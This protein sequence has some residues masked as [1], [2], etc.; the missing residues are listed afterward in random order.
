MEVSDP[1]EVA[2]TLAVTDDDGVPD[3]APV[4]DGELD[5]VAVEETVAHGVDVNV[6]ATVADTVGVEKLV[7][8]AVTDIDTVTVPDFPL[9]VDDGDTLAVNDADLVVD[10]VALPDAHDAV[11]L[12]VALRHAVPEFEK[13]RVG[14]GVAD[15]LTDAVIERD[16]PTVDETLGLLVALHEKRDEN[17]ARD[18][19]GVG[20]D[21][22]LSDAETDAVE[23][24]VLDG[25]TDTRGEVVVVCV[26][27]RE[28]ETETVADDDGVPLLDA[29]AV[30]LAEPPPLTDEVT[31]GD[32]DAAGDALD[33]VDDVPC[34]DSVAVV[35]TLDVND[36]EFEGRL[37]DVAWPL[38]LP[39]PLGNRDRDGDGV[40]DAL[41][42]T[43]P[44]VVGHTLELQ[45]V[46]GDVVDDDCDTG[47]PVGELLTEKEKVPVALTDDVAEF[48]ND[49]VGVVVVDALTRADVD[50]VCETLGD[51]DNE[52]VE[53]PLAV[54][55]LP[56]AVGRTVGV[57]DRVVDDVGVT[58][59]DALVVREPPSLRVAV[60]LVDTDPVEVGVLLCVVEVE[61]VRDPADERDVEK[62]SVPVAE[63]D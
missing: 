41:F 40:N 35:D 28:I 16:A 60:E 6:V 44:D 36:A 32:A 56:V 17:E 21:F 5:R 33:D 10:T 47:V 55:S 53:V 46:V 52:T 25:D 12:V 3:K 48:E 49:D 23:E 42:D 15:E 4:D 8:V 29:E 30:E 22:E 50:T 45:P 62:D 34:V 38:T 26:A 14:A 31:L 18:A 20:V 13:E 1:T 43:T 54:T 24:G 61:T 11:L 39:L 9:I 59:V 2:V 7:G 19:V 51:A 57:T 58:D 27:L 37:V 63:L